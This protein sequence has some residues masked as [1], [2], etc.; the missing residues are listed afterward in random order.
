MLAHCALEERLVGALY[1][2]SFYYGD[3]DWMPRDG[4]QNILNKNRYKN[5]HS[6]FFEI[7]KSDHHLYFD[8]PYD[9]CEKL[10]L[11]LSNLDE[12]KEDFKKRQSS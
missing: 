6:H 4:S 1:P 10:L 2:I 11:D 9:F 3:Y 8:N 5:T 7:E 12:L